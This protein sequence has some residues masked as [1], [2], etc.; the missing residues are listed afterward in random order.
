M[1]A[2]PIGIKQQMADY[3]TTGDTEM[4]EYEI[5]HDKFRAASAE[6][7]R[8]QMA[9]RAREIGDDVYLTARSVFNAASVE[10][11]T[12]EE[13]FHARHPIDYEFWPAAA[14]GRERFGS[15]M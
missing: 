5:A 11:G 7:R 12:A 13:A 6:F 2:C 14:P 15:D 10:F 8:M 3:R 4:K 9:Y 1:T